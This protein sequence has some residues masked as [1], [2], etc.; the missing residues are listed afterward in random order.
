MAGMLYIICVF[1]LESMSILNI[2]LDINLD[3][4]FNSLG[5]ATYCTFVQVRIIPARKESGPSRGS[6]LATNASEPIAAHSLLVQQMYINLGLAIIFFISNHKPSLHTRLRASVC[7]NPSLTSYQSGS[8]I[9]LCFFYLDSPKARC[10]T[11]HVP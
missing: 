10:S 5:T 8:K 4:I 3:I 11:C 2:N 1:G 9:P 7:E 6:P